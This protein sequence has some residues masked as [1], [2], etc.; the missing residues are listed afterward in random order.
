MACIP[1]NFKWLDQNSGSFWSIPIAINTRVPAHKHNTTIHLRYL[2]CNQLLPEIDKRPKFEHVS[3]KSH[4]IQETITFQRLCYRYHLN[5]ACASCSRHLDIT[6]STCLT[7][8]CYSLVLN[9]STHP[10]DHL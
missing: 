7:L 1:G 3:S 4:I 8:W 6:S 2:L 9:H 5:P 10:S